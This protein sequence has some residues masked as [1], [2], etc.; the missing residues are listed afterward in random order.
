MIKI[1]KTLGLNWV[2]GA[3]TGKQ[4]GAS[5]LVFWECLWLN[6]YTKQIKYDSIC[7][8]H[9][10]IQVKVTQVHTSNPRET[11]HQQC[12]FA[13]NTRPWCYPQSREDHSV[14][15]AGTDN[16]IS[17]HM[18]QLKSALLDSR[19][20]YMHFSNSVLEI[21]LGK[22][23]KNCVFCAWSDNGHPKVPSSTHAG[24]LNSS[25]EVRKFSLLLQKIGVI[26]KV[27]LIGLYQIRKFFF[28]ILHDKL[29]PE[30]RN[31]SLPLFDWLRWFERLTWGITAPK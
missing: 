6:H 16:R 13:C 27:R 3:K 29:F 31:S 12:L 14:W 25:Q 4:W 17:T 18:S 15:I 21:L 20:G 2:L 10:Y 19:L 5:P 11:E 1:H 24:N 7:I 26:E 22:R 23:T 30:V 8:V 9:F 28:A